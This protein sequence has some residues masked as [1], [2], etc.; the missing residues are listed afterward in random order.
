MSTDT[1][2]R[3]PLDDPLMLQLRNTLDQV[4][5]ADAARPAATPPWERIQQGMGR[6]RR[7]RRRARIARVGA[8]LLAL[9]VSGAAVVTGVVPYPAF[10]PTVVIPGSGGKS[11]LDDGRTRGSLAADTEWLKA[12]REH[13]AAGETTYESGGEFWGPP[14]ARKVDV[15]YAGDI[16]DY[17]VALVE[18]DWHWGPIASREQV[19]FQAPAGAGADRMEKGA[20]SGP[21]DLAVN[22]LTPGSMEES[23][24]SSAIVVLSATSVTVRLEE[25]PTI[26]AQAQVVRRR[27]TLP[28]DGGVYALA[29]KVSGVSALSIAEYPDYDQF[30]G[31]E[32]PEPTIASQAPA[33]GGAVES[34]EPLVGFATGMWSAARQPAGT[35]DDFRLLAAETPERPMINGP[36]RA[37]VGLIT[38]P[39]GARILAGGE[40]RKGGFDPVAGRLLSSG[41]D[42]NNLSI[43]WRRPAE[44]VTWDSGGQQSTGTD[45]G[46][47]AAMGPVGTARVQWIRRGGQIT[48]AAASNTITA[49]DQ[50]D[51][52][53]VR[54]VDD[55]GAIIGT[56]PVLES[57]IH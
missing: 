1:T 46:W 57:L 17:R 33:R 36:V 13:V 43:A 37:V 53:S 56:A 47:T 9:S 42:A 22:V 10:A 50:D 29:M 28:A 32:G 16:G 20:N 24:D 39:S 40:V 54:F 52:T 45:P 6:A 12:L 4:D 15:I 7:I 18:G 49:T 3:T 51:V 35:G 55:A 44:T 31:G 48:S 5:A 27:K 11:A 21:S 34:G 26:D 8:G 38:L 25:P 41:D 14:A 19:W 30:F 2:D 23:T